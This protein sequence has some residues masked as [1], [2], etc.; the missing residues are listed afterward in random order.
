MKHIA[1]TFRFQIIFLFLLIS[2]PAVGL[3]LAASRAN[4]EEARAQVVAAKQSSVNILVGQY[5]TSLAVVD[6][7][8]QL[9]LCMD[10]TYA[11]LRWGEANTRYQ[12][13]RVWLHDELSGLLNYFPLVSGFYVN[14]FHTDDTFM[15]KRK[16]KISLFTQEHLEEQ[17]LQREPYLQPCVVQC[18]EGKYLISGY[19]NSFMEIGFLLRLDDLQ[20]RFESGG[21]EGDLMVLSLGD[22]GEKVFLGEGDFTEAPGYGRLEKEFDVMPVELQLFFPEDTMRNRLSVRDKVLLSMTALL[23]AFIP[24]FLFAIKKWFL[25]PMRKV[26]TAMQEILD[27]NIDYRIQK[28]SNTREFCNIEQAFNHMLDYSQDLKIEAYELKLEKE[29]EELINLKLQINPHLLLNSLSVIYSLAFNRKTEE[30]REFSFNLSKYFRYALRNTSEFVTVRS[31]IEFVKTYTQVQKVRHP[32]AFFVMF[33]VDEDLMEERIPP[34]MIQNFVENSTKYALKPE[35]EIEIF[36]IVRREEDMLRIAICDDGRGMDSGLLEKI[37]E[38]EIIEDSR[39]RHVGIWNCVKR[40]RSFYG[41]KADFRI[42]SRKGEGTQ[43]WMEFPCG[44]AG[45]D[46]CERQ[47]V[48]PPRQARS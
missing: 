45:Q 34:L 16:N 39:G 24:V 43:V 20:E 22:K 28:F 15:A 30:I 7:Y 10:N 40:L 41:E 29:E 14:I 4:M 12:Q 36:V 3:S 21:N 42:T 31:E 26:S 37:L 9:L 35:G 5:D 44:K 17:I 27:G 13:A 47:N 11:A 48:Y 46:G 32:D 33:D 1:Y 2:V 38:G 18:E 23:A 19:R 8:L 25:V 6:N